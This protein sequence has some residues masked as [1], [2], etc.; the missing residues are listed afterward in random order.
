[1]GIGA[2]HEPQQRLLGALAE[3]FGVDPTDSLARL[4]DAWS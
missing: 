1:M 4:D 2:A 3:I